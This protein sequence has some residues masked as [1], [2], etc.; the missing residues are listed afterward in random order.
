M[1]NT[2]PAFDRAEELMHVKAGNLP[3]L[4]LAMRQRIC[5][6][7]GMCGEACLT[8]FAYYAQTI[9]G[10]ECYDDLYQVNPADEKWLLENKDTFSTWEEAAK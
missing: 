2:D 9:E 10:L 7:F 1:S 6:Q 4:A 5:K 3:P 8:A